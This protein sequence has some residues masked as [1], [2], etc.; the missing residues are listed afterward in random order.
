MHQAH[1][2]LRGNQLRKNASSGTI[3][4]LINIVLL[5]LSYPIYLNYL[6][7]EWYGLWATLSVVI[8][9][10]QMG[11]LGIHLAVARHIAEACGRKD[12]EEVWKLAMAAVCLM[13]FPC[14]LIIFVCFGFKEEILS[15]L[16]LENVYL[17]S[18]SSIFPFIGL[19]SALIL[20]V[21]VLKGV[22]IGIGKMDAANY[23]FLASRI[24]QFGTSVAFLIA[25]KGVVSLLYGACACYLLMAIAY[26]A[27]IY[28]TLEKIPTSIFHTTVGH[29]KKL[30]GFGAYIASANLVS[31]LMDPLN[32]ILLARYVGLETVTFYEIGL[33][34]VQVI[35]TVFESAIKAIMPAI[36]NLSGVGLGIRNTILRIHKKTLRLLCMTAVPAFTSL[37][38]FGD[39]A[40]RIWIGDNFS[41]QMVT[42][43]RWFTVGYLFNLMSVPS[44]YILLGL[45]QPQ[46]AFYTALLGSL[47]HFGIIVILLLTGIGVSLL[48]LVQTYTLAMIGGSFYIVLVNFYIMNHFDFSVLRQNK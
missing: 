5:L 30:I 39:I 37:F 42:T 17:K 34:G 36:G 10:S 13:L 44:F 9:M 45:D 8:V 32:K 19:L 21:E 20:M 28:F 7:V 24:V 11:N 2:F 15:M 48:L 1:Q 6:G 31:L 23:I 26:S 33:K 35:R 25:Q 12:I 40:L 29:V 43:L 18:A 16:S 14:F 46:H 3:V 38:I 22:I 4:A 41:E 47:V 27:Y